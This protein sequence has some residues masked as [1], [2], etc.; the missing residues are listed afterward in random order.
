M[1]DLSAVGGT[2]T[3]RKSVYWPHVPTAKQDAFLLLSQREAGYG[4]AAGGGKSEA[5]LMAALQYV[6]VPGYAALLLRR[7]YR[8]LA[9]PGALMDRAQDWLAGTDARWRGSEHA[10]HFPGGATIQ[11][12]HL[13]NE[14]DRFNYSS[15]EFQFIG[16]DELTEFTELTYRFMFSRLRRARAINV[17]L[18]MRWASNP[19]GIGHEWVRRRFIE[20]GIRMGRPFIPAK[21]GDN[22]H[23]DREEYLESLNQLDPVTRAQLLNGD[24]KARPRGGMFQRER[25]FMV[26]WDEVPEQ[27]R[28]LRFWD[29]AAT[30]PRPGKEPDASAGALVGF[31]DGDWYIGDI[32]WFQAEPPVVEK[33]LEQRARE[34][35]TAVMI[36]MEQEPGSSGKIAA[37]HF[38]RRVFY[39]YDFAAIRSTGS[40][41]VRAAPVSAAAGNGHVYVVRGPWVSAFFDEIESFPEGAHD[42]RVDAVSGAVGALASEG[43]PNLRFL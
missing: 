27:I 24:W 12:G 19:G 42:D 39:G 4:G 40:K 5:L 31:Y 35:G 38:A 10:W 36:R 32:D 26:D 30:E 20:E 1:I 11:F 22:P 18:R 41:A 13:Q 16:F 34:D 6:D 15:S 29:L 33:R 43:T 28:W 14:R 7:T 21:L 3:P 37:D 25:F 9:Q 23:L 8:N 2:V 17:P